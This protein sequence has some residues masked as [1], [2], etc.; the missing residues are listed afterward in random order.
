M[1]NRMKGWGPGILDFIVRL[2][3]ALLILF[4]ASRI[5]KIISRI[6]NNAMERGVPG[7]EC[8]ADAYHLDRGGDLYA[9]CIYCS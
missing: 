9:G 2:L 3:I 7:C 5:V 8:D 4:I 1:M 6:M